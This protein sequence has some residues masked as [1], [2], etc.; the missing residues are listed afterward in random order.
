MHVP[1][2]KHSYVWLPRKWDHRIDIQTDRYTDARQSVP[3]VPL[4]FAGQH[5]NRP[6]IHHKVPK[7]KLK[8]I[9][10]SLNAIHS[11]GQWSVNWQ[12]DGQFLFLTMD[13]LQDK[14]CVLRNTDA[15]GGNKVQIWQKSLSP[16]FWPCP[17]LRGM[18]CQWS[19]SNPYMNLQSKFGY[20]IISQTLN[21]ALYV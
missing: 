18:W 17:N 5:K 10:V 9:Y 3:Y 15:P 8:Y 14:T 20:C 11:S 7:N 1:P 6:L 4:C 13:T 21:I 12:V 2:A 19:V 16:K